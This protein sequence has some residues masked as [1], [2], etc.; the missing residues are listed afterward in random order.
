MGLRG[1]PLNLIRIMPAK[2]QGNAVFLIAEA[3]S[4]CKRWGKREFR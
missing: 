1:D 3:N 2:E 4:N